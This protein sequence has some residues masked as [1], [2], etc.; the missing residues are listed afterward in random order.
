M[1][2]YAESCRSASK[3]LTVSP[4]LA[5]AARRTSEVTNR[6][7]LRDRGTMKLSKAA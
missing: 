3:T 4:T 7:N 5:P 1:V 6:K 2:D